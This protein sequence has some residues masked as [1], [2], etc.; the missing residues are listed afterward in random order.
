MTEMEGSSELYQVVCQQTQTP[1]IITQYDGQF[2]SANPS[3]IELFH[4]PKNNL[5][6]YTLEQL[7][8]QL[9]NPDAL[10][11]SIPQQN[12]DDIIFQVSTTQSFFKN[13]PIISFVLTNI[14]L[15]YQTEKR[16][17]DGMA[18]SAAI[19][20]SVKDG[21]LTLDEHG[22]VINMNIA[23]EKI[24]GY[25]IGEVE[26]QHISLLVPEDP[27][28][29]EEI[30]NS[31]KVNNQLPSHFQQDKNIETLG[32][33][34]KGF[35]FPIELSVR[36]FSLENKVFYTAVISDIS[37]RKLVESELER[38]RAH[39]QEMV[40]MATSEVNAIVQTTV[41]GVITINEKGDVQLFNPAAEKLFGWQAS[42]IIGRNVAVLVPEIDEQTHNRYIQ[43]YLDTKQP[44]IVGIGREVE[45]RHKDGSNFPAHLSIGYSDQGHDQHL[46]VAF[47]TDISDQK[48]AEKELILAKEKAEDAARIKA[49]FLANMSHEIRTPMN[50]IIGYSEVI[51]E[52][53]NLTS[54]SRRHINT[55]INSG[56]NL[57]SIINDILDF[58]KIESGQIKLEHVCYHL[59]N[60]TQDAL[61]TLKFKALE[62]NLYL[63]LITDPALPQKVIGDPS[64]LRQVILNLIGNAIKF[65][66]QGSITLS[67][68]PTD[69][70]DFVHFCISDTGIGMSE[71]QIK[72]VFEAFSQADAS[73]NRRFG[74]T[75]LGTT[76][77]KQIVELMQGNIWIESE[78]GQGSHF[79][80]VIHLPQAPDNLIALFEEET[81]QSKN[82]S[83]PRI[84]NILLAEDLA[85]NAELAMLRLEQQGHNVTWVENGELALTEA[86]DKQY[87][88]VLM[89]IQMPEMDGLTASRLIRQQ[90]KSSATPIPIIAL[91]ASVLKED[92]QDCFDAGM[93]AI[94]GKPINFN[95]MFQAMEN[96]VPE[97]RGIIRSDIEGTVLN[98]GNSSNIR[99]CISQEKNRENLI[100]HI[101]LTVLG[102][103]VDYKKGLATWGDPLIYT[104]AILSLLNERTQDS[105]QITNALEQS[106]PDIS[107]AQKITHALKGLSGNLYLKHIANICIQI[108]QNLKENQIPQ[109]I[110]LCMALN[111]AVQR[112]QV[113]ASLLELPEIDTDSSASP[114]LTESE[115][116]QLLSKVYI[117]ADE[118]NPDII[119]PL[120]EQVESSCDKAV[121]K[122]LVECTES[123]DFD[124][125]KSETEA[126]M[127]KLTS[128]DQKV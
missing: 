3:A 62:K 123:F 85:T 106:P 6:S 48:K 82:Y 7:I 17:W 103:E 119:M 15:R 104:K 12:Q 114:A 68:K 34:K 25:F 67:I 61:Q 30:T 16:A 2:I 70:P 81:S 125:L 24:F 83:S 40:L 88:L 126:F 72:H 45:A 74:G 41:N 56:N 94:V 19:I 105:Q 37:E 90:S 115:L 100:A 49:N 98:K 58:S 89:D 102:D 110:E 18:R 73:T 107:T 69:I 108:E 23:G 44:R 35:T 118:L 76:I 22:N 46:F 86:L 124:Q 122:S 29:S 127:A 87:D 75:G 50:A 47:I 71:N 33:H 54:S 8:P 27:N 59:K 78:L 121:F 31:G 99:G 28:G 101:D 26:G 4:L 97:N 14:S 43:R 13:T 84:F 66:H 113:N 21:I 117:A 80:F 1:I 55:I 52:D 10:Q 93:D 38:H 91:T 95:E 65:T 111:K 96:L 51:K 53:C 116:T 77:S 63:E 20:D 39:L 9:A 5:T 60:A 11:I 128:S 32:Q 92:Q 109:T 57:L 42:D 112:L 79:H 36:C 120:L 64:R